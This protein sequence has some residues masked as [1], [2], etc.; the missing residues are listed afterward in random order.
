MLD[1]LFQSLFLCALLLFW[2]CV[3]HGI[4]VQ[5]GVQLYLLTEKTVLVY[6]A[7]S[8][9]DKLK[10]LIKKKSDILILKY[11]VRNRIKMIC[12]DVECTETATPKWDKW[13]QSA[14]SFCEPVFGIVV[15]LFSL[16]E[17]YCCLWWLFI[18]KTTLKY[19]IK[20]MWILGQ[21]PVV[22]VSVKYVGP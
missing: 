9:G 21:I 5:V 11:N 22:S 18:F 20:E 14:Q 4:R 17:F 8:K 7:I 6:S 19:C 12:G 2:L 10:N 16:E 13:R 15:L 1:D 3:Y